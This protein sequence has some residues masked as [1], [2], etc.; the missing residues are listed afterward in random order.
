MAW[1]PRLRVYRHMEESGFDARMRGNAAH[2]AMEL[3]RITGDDQVDARRA[4]TLALTDFPVLAA[5]PEDDRERLETEIDAMLA[6]VLSRP[7][8]RG[9]LASGR[10]E[11]SFLD[12]DGAPLRPD[13]LHLGKTENVILEFKTGGRDP[14]HALQTRHYLRLVAQVFPN[15]PVRG[16]VVYLDLRETD[17][18][19]G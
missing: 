11:A 19:E 16:V 7:D 3:L 10:S 1:L 13:V 6:W 8:L 14:A 15:R 4:R 2:R 17:V 12:A 18:V 5:L 9:W